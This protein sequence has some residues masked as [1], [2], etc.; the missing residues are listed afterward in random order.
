M[1]IAQELTRV[2][3]KWDLLQHPFY[4]AWSAGTL[5]TDALKT[6]ASEYGA[7]IRLL[8]DGWKLLGDAQTAQEE[9]EHAELWD[10][11]AT[12]LGTKV[13]TKS[14]IPQVEM[15]LRGTTHLFTDP[16]SAVGA[17]YA[18]EVQQPATAESKLNGLKTHYQYPTHPELYFELHRHKHH[19]RQKLLERIEA[20]S[21]DEQH[22]AARS[23][24][25]MAEAL[26]DALSGIYMPDPMSHS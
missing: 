25:E 18:F 16:A 17:L 21:D 14:H 19:T 2:V 26:W 15:L 6:Y 7:F 3:S 11:F 23:C 24:A 20:L 10:R 22:L 13:T 8:P 1:S 12:A 9:L 4:Q 5:P